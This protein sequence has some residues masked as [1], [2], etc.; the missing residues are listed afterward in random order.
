MSGRVRPQN[1]RSWLET[2]RRMSDRTV[3]FIFIL[4]LVQLRFNLRLLPLVDVARDLVKLEI[5]WQI[6]LRTL[7]LAQ[8]EK[9]AMRNNMRFGEFLIWKDYLLLPWLEI[10]FSTMPGLSA[11]S[12][13]G[14]KPRAALNFWPKFNGD[15]SRNLIYHKTIIIVI[16]MLIETMPI[17]YLFKI[18][19]C[20]GCIEDGN[21]KNC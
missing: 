15:Q 17:I 7:K 8:M 9:I 12:A 11:T 20:N 16:S 13:S 18:K 6:S 14:I 19:R 4:P 1:Q 2:H 5:A 3:T 10:V 21:A